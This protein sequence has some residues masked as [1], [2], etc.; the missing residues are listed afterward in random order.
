MLTE[1]VKVFA[2]SVG[3]KTLL[4]SIAVYIERSR[5]RKKK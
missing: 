1:F 3:L 4:D 2:S 5:E